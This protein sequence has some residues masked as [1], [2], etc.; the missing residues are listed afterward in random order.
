M[1]SH[2]FSSTALE[3]QEVLVAH[4]TDLMI[5]RLRERVAKGKDTIDLIRWFQYAALNIMG[6]FCFRESFH[7]L[8]NV[9]NHPW[10]AT[11]CDNVKNCQV[12]R[13]TSEFSAYGVNDACDDAYICQEQ[14]AKHFCLV[15]RT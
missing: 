15:P 11:I 9:E 1:L 10:I 4:Y 5:E 14:D 3:E 6:D 2:A 7:C 12:R 8:E 13:C